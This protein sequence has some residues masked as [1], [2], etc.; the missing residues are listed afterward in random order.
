MPASVSFLTVNSLMQDGRKRENSLLLA[1]RVCVYVE[2]ES[3]CHICSVSIESE[4]FSGKKKLVRP[5]CSNGN[6]QNVKKDWLLV[7]MCV[8]F[9]FV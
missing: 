5:I 8:K 4:I 3:D 6:N 7:F 2:T 1:N 9:L